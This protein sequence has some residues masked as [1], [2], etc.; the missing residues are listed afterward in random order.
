MLHT[1][2][3]RFDVTRNLKF[4]AKFLASKRCLARTR[5]Y[6][7]TNHIQSDHKFT[8]QNR[9]AIFN[10]LTQHDEKSLVSK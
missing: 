7:E 9:N 3:Q 2:V 10:K 4:L 5:D 6:E 8:S 1:C